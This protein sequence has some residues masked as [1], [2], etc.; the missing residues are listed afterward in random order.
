MSIVTCMY[1]HVYHVASSLLVNLNF[2][3]NLANLSYVVNERG[4]PLMS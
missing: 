2:L 1:N 3:I 4:M